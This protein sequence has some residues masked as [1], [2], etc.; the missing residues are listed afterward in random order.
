[1]KLYAMNVRW[2]CEARDFV[3]LLE[4]VGEDRREKALSHRFMKDRALSLG[5]GLL[6]NLAL[7]REAP[8]VS[9]PPRIRLGEYGKPFLTEQGAPFFSLSHSGEYAA[10]AVGA[11]EVGLDIEEVGMADSDVARRCFTPSELQRVM[12]GEDAA[13]HSFTPR[14]LKRVLPD[15]DAASHCF[16]PSELQRGIPDGA[17]VDAEAFCRLWTMKESF[18]KRIGTGL[19]L[20][21]LDF[22]IPDGQPLRVRRPQDAQ[23]YFLKLYEELPGYKLALCATGG[24]FPERVEFVERGELLAAL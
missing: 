23:D 18:I 2:L 24:R 17:R 21:P 12:P 8:E 16:S 11:E 15:E 10:C 14:E 22:E 6:L 4:C 19:S 7:A 1:M 5:A 20:D 13:S 9:W 3:G